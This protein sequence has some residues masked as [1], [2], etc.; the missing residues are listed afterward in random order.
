MGV[1]SSTS[2]PRDARLLV[3]CDTVVIIIIL[4]PAVDLFH[5]T[6]GPVRDVIG[7]QRKM[8]TQ[9]KTK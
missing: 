2:R 6:S 4:V 7:D 1:A 8:A 5:D 3:V 9:R